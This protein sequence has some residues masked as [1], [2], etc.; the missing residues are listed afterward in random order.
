MSSKLKDISQGDLTVAVSDEITTKDEIGILSNSVSN[1]V[2]K[3]RITVVEINHNATNLTDASRVIS[4]SSQQLLDSANEQAAS[5]EEVSSS[6]EKIVVN[7]EHNNE[8]SRITSNK[9][10]ALHL[11]V[12]D[13]NQKAQKAVNSHE[14]INDKIVIIK[15]IANQTNIL[16]LNAAVEAAR[17]GEQGKGFAVVASEIRKLAERSKKAAEDIISLSE[18]TKEL[19]NEAGGSLMAI[20]PEIEKTAKLIGKITTASEEQKTDVE[21]VKNS[22][23][24]LSNV[25]QQN[26][27]ISEELTA[28]SED[29]EAQAERL[30]DLINYFKVDK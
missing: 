1:M 27:A 14:T 2:E 19:S 12:L 25:A 13:V 5:T 24:Q 4:N 17:A 7:V 15:E 11:G 23:L 9:S 21:Q 8:N 26:A 18:N 16:A 10:K 6:M 20:V 28:T 29:M 22:I 3:L 30:R